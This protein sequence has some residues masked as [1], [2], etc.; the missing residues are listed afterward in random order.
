MREL[1]AL[2][3]SLPPDF[4]T[5]T[6]LGGGG[7]QKANTIPDLHPFPGPSA[8]LSK[9]FIRF[10]VSWNEA[11]SALCSTLPTCYC[12]SYTT[13]TWSKDARS[14][15]TTSGRELG[16]TPNAGKHWI[17]QGF[18]MSTEVDAIKFGST[19]RPSFRGEPNG[20]PRRK[21]DMH[22]LRGASS[23]DCGRVTNR[24]GVLQTTHPAQ[25]AVPMPVISRCIPISAKRVP[26]WMFRNCGVVH[27]CVDAA[28]MLS[29]VTQSTLREQG[30]A[31]NQRT[32]SI[33]VQEP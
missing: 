29:L 21:H 32:R 9:F 15:M 16:R 31:A 33:A 22:V 30:S 1:L 10:L 20:I 11:I 18:I 13:K 17:L 19:A 8:S 27:Y 26:Q 2:P 12:P 14:L 4:R 3:P 5:A 6:T 24:G 28:I 7:G 23:G 25:F